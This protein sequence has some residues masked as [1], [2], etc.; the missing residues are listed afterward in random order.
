MEKNK[1]DIDEAIRDISERLE[2]LEKKFQELEE[3][4]R[5]WELQSERSG[6]SGL[7][8]RSVDGDTGSVRSWK[9]GM[10]RASRR[11]YIS[12]S[13]KELVKMK[14]IVN[15]QN[16]NERRNNIVI[17]GVEPIGEN[18]KEWVENF[19]SLKLEV[20]VKIEF[21]KVSG[22]VIIA[23]VEGERKGEIMRNKSKLKGT[24]I[25]IENDL[26]IED[27]KRQEELHRWVKEKKEEGWNVKP[28]TGRVFCK[29]VWRKWEGKDEIER[30][31]EKIR[32]N[33]QGNDSN[34]EKT[35]E[36]R[37]EKDDRGNNTEKN[38]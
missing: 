19:S 12:L 25:Y 11:S 33:P 36:V 35:V 20:N 23:K 18:I 6:A 4:E 3:R 27:R 32:E 26:N 21:A 31:M 16:R 17:R 29:G 8:L 1:V 2:R 37:D 28:G 10:T 13:D 7:G 5:E 30:E 22:R 15:E 34:T 38:F 24:R 14:R 9:S